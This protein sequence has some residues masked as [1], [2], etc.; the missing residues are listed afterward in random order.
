MLGE[1]NFMIPAT[2]VRAFRV[3]SH[4]S[5]CLTFGNRDVALYRN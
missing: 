1:S 5:S 3:F 2:M 4:R